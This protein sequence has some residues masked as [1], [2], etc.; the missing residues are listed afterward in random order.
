VISLARHKSWESAE[1]RFIASFSNTA[2]SH[3]KFKKSAALPSKV[4]AF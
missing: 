2:M 1:R 4:R 3:R